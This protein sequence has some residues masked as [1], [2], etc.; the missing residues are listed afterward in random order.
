MVYEIY[1]DPFPAW[2]LT[3]Y[4]RVTSEQLAECTDV[5]PA[6]NQIELHPFFN[7]QDMREMNASLGI[8]GV[9]VA[10]R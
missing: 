3:N 7:Q 10:S 2:H 6:V 5:L 8:V 4:E 9:M 1:A